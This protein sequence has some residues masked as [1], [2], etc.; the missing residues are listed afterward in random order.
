VRA[1]TTGDATA[2]KEAEARR[3]GGGLLASSGVPVLA[4]WIQV[5]C[6]ARMCP[7]GPREGLERARGGGAETN[8]FRARMEGRLWDLVGGGR[9]R[10]RRGWGTWRTWG[11][12]RRSACPL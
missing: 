3:G 5:G 10:G 7:Y 8:I 9:G 12:G 1:T 2:L 4:K 11:G 6:R